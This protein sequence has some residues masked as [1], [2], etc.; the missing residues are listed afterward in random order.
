M[1]FGKLFGAI[2]LA[3]VGGMAAASLLGSVSAVGTMKKAKGFAASARARADAAEHAA[4]LSS[5]MAGD[6]PLHHEEPIS[7]YNINDPGAGEFA[8]QW[9]VKASE[10]LILDALMSGN[11]GLDEET[12]GTV[13]ANVM[14]DIQRRHGK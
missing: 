4:L 3:P 12:V 1:G 11:H 8:G 14:A 10:K 13:F 7:K 5:L 6:H 9:D 2:V